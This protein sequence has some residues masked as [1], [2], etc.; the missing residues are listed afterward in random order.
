MLTPFNS[1][2]FYLIG[3]AGGSASGKTYL[4]EQIK[5]KFGEHEVCILSQ[6]DYYR[7]KEEQL[8]D[9]NGVINYDLPNSINEEKFLEDLQLLSS[10]ETLYISEYIFNNPEKKSSVKQIKPAPIII[11]EGLFIFHFLKIREKLHL[12]IFVEAKEEIKLFRRLQRDEMERGI[13]QATILYQW[14]QH[15]LP[16]YIRYLLP[17]REK[18]DVVFNNH[19]GMESAVSILC[20]HLNSKLSSTIFEQS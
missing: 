11:V 3:I 5:S 8:L 13:P 20:D 19:T 16:A 17:H 2:Q 7:P 9:E 12:K 1:K 14:H 15:V 18:A 4:L 10:G 6:D